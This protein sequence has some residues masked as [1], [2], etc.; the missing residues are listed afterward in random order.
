MHCCEWGVF[1]RQG[2]WTKKGGWWVGGGKHFS[3]R[4]CCRIC[5][6]MFLVA[7]GALSLDS[8]ESGERGGW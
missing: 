5:I 8:R 7:D 1:N 6:E 2:L 3:K 4:S